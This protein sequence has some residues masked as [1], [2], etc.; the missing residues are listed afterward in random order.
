MADDAPPASSAINQQR[1]YRRHRAPA[2][3][4]RRQRPRTPALADSAAEAT[5][6]K[7]RPIHLP[8]RRGDVTLRRRAIFSAPAKS[9]P[10]RLRRHLGAAARWPRRRGDDDAA[11]IMIKRGRR[12]AAPAIR[13]P[14]DSY[15]ASR[16][17]MNIAIELGKCP[18]LFMAALRR[19]A[20]PRYSESR[21]GRRRPRVGAALTR[22]A[23]RR[24]RRRSREAAAP[25]AALIS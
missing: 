19:Q 20:T 13:R 12:R 16:T 3:R 10:R 18:G 6:A 22:F 7:H 24:R 4:G 9:S 5:M 2:Y 11:D 15:T 25:R 23:A 14:A 1:R 17:A 8:P 21:R